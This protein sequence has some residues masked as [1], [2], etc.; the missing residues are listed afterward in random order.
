MS[1]PLMLLCASLGLTFGLRGE[2]T[3]YFPLQTGN[4]WEYRCTGDCAGGT[5]TRE[6]VATERPMATLESQ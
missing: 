5:F 6:I 1:A 2:P 3:P 4:R